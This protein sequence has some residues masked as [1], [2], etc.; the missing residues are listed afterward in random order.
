MGN[1]VLA[2]VACAPKQTELRE[3][4]MPE[5]PHDG[6]LLRVE[7]VGVCGTDVANYATIQRPRI[8]GHHVVG[9][10]AGIGRDA[11]ERWGLREGD[12]VAM[13]EYI[14]C[15]QC[16]ECRQGRYRAC[17]FTD[18]RRGGLR[19]GNTPIDV[20]PA[21]WGGFAEYLY[22]HPNAVMHR[23]PEHV[24]P[25]EAVMTLPL[26]NGFE[27]MD[28]ECHVRFGQIVV[29]Q[30]P[31]QQGLACLLA[32]K[33]LGATVIVVGRES[34]RKRLEL[35][36][37]LGA[38]AIVNVT[39]EDLLD[40][41]LDFTGGRRVDVA[42]DVTSGGWEPVKQSFEIVRRGGIVA[43]AAYKHQTIPEWDIDQV[44]AKSLIVKGLRGHSHQS[45]EMAIDCIASRRFPIHLLN[46][47]HFGLQDTD[48]ALRTAGGEGEPNPLLVAVSPGLGGR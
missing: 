1:T 26:A 41:V 9:F 19:Y 48:T 36:R 40:K 16:R 39:R 30:G 10:V 27:W 24:S 12:R 17:A 15:G 32:A 38:D 25:V 11:A 7:T 33:A 29:I 2:A 45:V 4:P 3:F 20:T 18:S 47:H 42:I 14:P 8:L 28:M 31:G 44:V 46:S 34:S 43:L 23:M 37:Q 13:E 22:L 35:A 21:L 5:V 6:G